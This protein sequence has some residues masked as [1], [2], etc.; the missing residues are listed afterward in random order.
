MNTF[1]VSFYS[2]VPGVTPEKVCRTMTV[3]VDGN[4]LH[5]S[6]AVEAINTMLKVLPGK[7]VG[8]E[9]SDIVEISLVTYPFELTG[10]EHDERP[11]PLYE[12]VCKFGLIGLFIV[13][14]AVIAKEMF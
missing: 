7:T 8:I 9:E 14:A 11:H 6:E 13:L 3:R 4:T 12:M 1:N 10:G 2:N 5:V